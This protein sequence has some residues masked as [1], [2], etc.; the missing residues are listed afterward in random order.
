[1]KH[2]QEVTLTTEWQTFDLTLDATAFGLENSRILFDMGADTGVVM[3]DDVV[4]KNYWIG[5]AANVT[6][7][8]LG[9]D[10]SRANFANLDAPAANSF[11]VNL[12]QIVSITQGETYTLIFKAL[13]NV[14]RTLIA[15]I[16][17]NEGDYTNNSRVVDLTTEMLVK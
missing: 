9:F 13:S 8:L 6:D 14:E 3:L 10:G 5:N 12:S 16:G 15:G 11:D 17:L 1:M 7:E 2:P 4:L